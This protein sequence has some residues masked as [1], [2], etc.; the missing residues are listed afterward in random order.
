MELLKS[1]WEHAQ[2]TLFCTISLDSQVCVGC[3]TCYDV[4]P[5]GCF[6]PDT[7]G[8]RVALLHPEHCLACGACQLQC[9]PQAVYLVSSRERS[10]E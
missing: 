5:V 8:E 10:V 9:R 2:A 3:M 7:T 6:Y 4:C 1:F